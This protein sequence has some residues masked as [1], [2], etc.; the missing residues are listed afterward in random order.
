MKIPSRLHP[1]Q[2]KIDDLDDLETFVKY[3]DE[4]FGQMR[5]VSMEVAVV[6]DKTNFFN[7]IQDLICFQH[8]INP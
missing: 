4:N 3:R 7:V 2:G 8:L 6:D 1:A 5:N